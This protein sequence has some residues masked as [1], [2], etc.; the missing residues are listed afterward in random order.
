LNRIRRPDNPIYVA[1][2]AG[3]MRPVEPQDRR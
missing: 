2:F 1:L 3:E